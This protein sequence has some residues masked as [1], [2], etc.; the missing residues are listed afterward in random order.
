MQSKLRSLASFDQR[1]GYYAALR[2]SEDQIKQAEA[3]LNT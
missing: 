1:K 3:A 2:M